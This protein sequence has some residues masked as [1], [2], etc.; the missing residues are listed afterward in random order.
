MDCLLWGT[1]LLRWE[2]YFVEQVTAQ[3]KESLVSDGT[4]HPRNILHLHEIC[5][6]PS[7]AENDFMAAQCNLASTL[8]TQWSTVTHLIKI[9]E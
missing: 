2:L 3:N 4:I 8:P 6:S 1:T 5:R 9:S 7:L